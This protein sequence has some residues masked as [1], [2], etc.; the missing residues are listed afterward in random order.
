M[1][2][3]KQRKCLACGK[4]YLPDIRIGSKQQYCSSPPCQTESHRASQARWF[5]KPE[6]RKYYHGSHHVD[7]VRAWQ[8]A[9]PDWRKRRRKRESGLHDVM[10][11]EDHDV[12]EVTKDEHGGLHDLMFSQPPVVLGLVASLTGSGTGLHDEIELTL[13]KMHSHGQAILGMR[14]GTQMKGTVHHG[15]SQTSVTC[16]ETAACAAAVQ[17]GGSPADKR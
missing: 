10:K 5:R 15:S 1:R 9:H 8:K 4:M 14:P 7:R 11:S 3:R 2:H 17:L 16:A 12:V 13:R 6:N